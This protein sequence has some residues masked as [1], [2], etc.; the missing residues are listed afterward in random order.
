MRELLKPVLSLFIICFVV[1]L[2]L[3]VVNFYTCDVIAQRAI[4]DAATVRKQVLPAADFFTEKKDWIPRDASSS[5]IRE[6]YLGTASGKPVGLV[7]TAWS[8]GYA[9]EIK[10]LVGIGLDGTITGVQVIEQKETPGLGAKTKEAAFVR[11]YQNKK[12]GTKWVVVKKKPV[13]EQEIQAI[14]GATISSKAV[15]LAVQMAC[16]R[17]GIILKEKVEP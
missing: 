5:I 14:S 9:G 12:I 17:S 3:S 8:K 6:V 13:S 10:V 2:C 7:C 11:Q 1:A 4:Q 15:T 16:E